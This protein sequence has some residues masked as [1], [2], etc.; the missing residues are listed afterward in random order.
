[1]GTNK[2]HLIRKRKIKWMRHHFYSTDQHKL[3]VSE[4]TC[5]GLFGKWSCVSG[6]CT[7]VLGIQQ[8]S[9][10]IFM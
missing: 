8:G 2:I 6:K 3:K 1:M 5:K 7:E 10:T 9:Q 4:H